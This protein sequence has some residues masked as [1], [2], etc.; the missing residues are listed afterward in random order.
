MTSKKKK[1]FTE[2]GKVKQNKKEIKKIVEEAKKPEPKKAIKQSGSAHNVWSLEGIPAIGP[3]NVNRLIE[4][5]ITSYHGLITE[6]PVSIHTL[7]G[8]PMDKCNSAVE[9]CQ[10]ALVDSGKMSKGQRSAL[11]IFTERKGYGILPTGN[12][13]L[14]DQLGGGI[15]ESSL[16]EVYGAFG[17]GKTQ[18]GHTLCVMV[19]MPP[20]YQCPRCKTDYK[21]VGKCKECHD[22]KK[23][24]EKEIKKYI[25]LINLGGLDGDVYYIDTENTFSPDRIFDIALGRGLDPMKVLERI[26][27]TRVYS[28]HEQRQE[29]TKIDSII[30]ENQ[31]SGGKKIKLIIVDSMVALPRAEYQGVDTSLGY[32]ARRQQHINHMMNTLKRQSELFKLVVLVTNQVYADVNQQFGDNTKPVGGNAMGHAPTIRLYLKKAGKAD[33]QGQKGICRMIDSPS[34]PNFEILYCLTEDEGFTDV[35]PEKKEKEID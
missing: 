16:T 19:Q 14:D 6:G 32:L 23:V 26:T 9:H 3:T 17:S 27:V 11:D 4:S 12:H 1:E 5:G 35:K 22:I 21:R 2:T 28:T 31:A 29:I 13:S 30:S 34:H 20:H 25:D 33:A 10:K 8:I 24:G 18:F 7:T 15:E